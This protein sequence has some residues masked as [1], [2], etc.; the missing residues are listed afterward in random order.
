MRL[1]L[2]RLIPCCAPPR[3]RLLV[4]LSRGL[5]IRGPRPARF[6][7]GCFVDGRAFDPPDLGP[8]AVTWALDSGRSIRA[9]LTTGIHP[10]IGGD[11]FSVML[12]ALGSCSGSSP[13]Y[14]Q[15]STKISRNY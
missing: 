14:L 12:G 1:S 2:F 3:G 11:G 5:F 4:C 15:K 13:K 6:K 10:L 9:A 8:R 7:A